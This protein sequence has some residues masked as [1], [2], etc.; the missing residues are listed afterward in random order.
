[1]TD[2]FSANET[3]IRGYSGIGAEG[4]PGVTLVFDPVGFVVTADAGAGVLTGLGLDAAG[5]GTTAG[6]I[7]VAGVGV[8][9]LMGAGRGV[10]ITGGLRTGAEIGTGVGVDVGIVA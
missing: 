3:R 10:G 9:T 1:M 6:G 2:G 8:M 7:I 4:P 5:T